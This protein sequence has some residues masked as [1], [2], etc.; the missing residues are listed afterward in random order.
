LS[1]TKK[2]RVTSTSIHLI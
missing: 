1:Y 2:K